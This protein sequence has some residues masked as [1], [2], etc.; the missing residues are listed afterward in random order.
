MSLNGPKAA[1]TKHCCTSERSGLLVNAFAKATS[2]LH[3]T[4]ARQ[5]TYVQ[6]TLDWNFV[7]HVDVSNGAADP[8]N[9]KCT[10]EKIE[11]LAI[12]EC[13]LGRHFSTSLRAT[14]ANLILA[15]QARRPRIEAISGRAKCSIF[16]TRRRVRPGS[17]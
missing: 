16:A 13:W 8:G 9:L 15:L 12:I 11:L 10:Q 7:G 1:E 17:A 3:A 4:F 14:G 6:T 2:G 5:L